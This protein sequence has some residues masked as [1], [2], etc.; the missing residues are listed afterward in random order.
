MRSK[1]PINVSLPEDDG[2]AKSRLYVVATVLA[3]AGI[4]LF[5]SLAAFRYF[6]PSQP[7]QE[8]AGEIRLIVESRLLLE[9]QDAK[10]KA[11]STCGNFTIS[12]DGNEIC[13]G[14]SGQE[15]SFALPAGNHSITA[16]GGNCTVSVPVQVVR[17]EC[18]DGEIKSC[19]RDGCAGKS[20]CFNGGWGGCVLP[21]KKCAPGTR[22]GC[23][24]NS[25]S[26][27]YA[28][29]DKCGT[30]FGPCLPDGQASPLTGN[31]LSC[32]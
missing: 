32:N 21:S 6:S 9:G 16:S 10:F 29:C 12:A 31:S 3:C 24:Y 27:G 30:G 2:S 14:T 1:P 26:F 25:C 5:A 23:A 4:V 11:Y 28:T 13:E 18:L 15:F 8:E 22:I 19:E 7:L 17:P 20:T